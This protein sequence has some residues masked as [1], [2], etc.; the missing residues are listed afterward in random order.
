MAMNMQAKFFEEMGDVFGY[1]LHENHPLWSAFQLFCEM[2]KEQ[3][4][5]DEDE[6]DDYA[7]CCYCNKVLSAD[8]ET[9]ILNDNCVCLECYEGCTNSNKEWCECGEHYV[10]K[11]NHWS[12]VLCFADC[13]D[14][15][16]RKE[17][18]EHYGNR[19]HHDMIGEDEYEEVGKLLNEDEF[20]N[21]DCLCGNNKE[22]GWLDEVGGDMICEDCDIDG[23]NPMITE[24]DL[25]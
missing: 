17:V 24:A 2:T 23:S 16:S 10:D 1:E 11:E 21:T 5:S 13:K 19:F 20:K 12:S 15:V 14:C 4:E 6:T 25:P 18:L 9:K 7:E 8:E 22:K 3:C